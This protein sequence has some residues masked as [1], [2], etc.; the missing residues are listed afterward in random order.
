MLFDVQAALTEILSQPPE[1]DGSR[2]LKARSEAL[3]IPAIVATNETKIAEI[4]E[5]AAP[6]VDYSARA[7]VLPF[8]PPPSAPASSR[9]DCSTFPHGASVTGLPRTWTGRVVSLD[10]WRTLTDWQKHGPAG[11]LF[12]GA[13]QSWIKPGDCPHIEGGAT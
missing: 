11:R 2:S 4:A 9:D 1:V 8:T 3:A 6:P 13:C 7:N 12:C 5:I 10:E